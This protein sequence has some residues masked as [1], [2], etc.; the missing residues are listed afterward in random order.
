MAAKKSKKHQMTLTQFESLMNKNANHMP[1]DALAVCK[2]AIEHF[3]ANGMPVDTS[4]SLFRI[5]ADNEADLDAKLLLATAPYVKM[6]MERGMNE[7]QYAQKVDAIVTA[8]AKA[9]E[10]IEDPTL[11]LTVKVS[12]GKKDKA[13]DRALKNHEMNF[14]KK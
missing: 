11:P 5:E 14:K 1:S 9:K 7:K 8:V 10:M 4:Y 12:G 2:K 13:R 3:K 6:L